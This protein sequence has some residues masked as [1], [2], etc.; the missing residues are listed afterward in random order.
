MS[1][2]PLPCCTCDFRNVLYVLRRAMLGGVAIIVPGAGVYIII[3]YK[4]QG[5]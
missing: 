2:W 4:R 5:T 1:I 3:G